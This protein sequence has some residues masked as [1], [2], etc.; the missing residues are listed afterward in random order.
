MLLHLPS[1]LAI[2]CVLTDFENMW[3]SDMEKGGFP[4]SV[5]VV[6]CE[7]VPCLWC[8]NAIGGRSHKAGQ[9][10]RGH[11]VRWPQHPET[12]SPGVKQWCVCYMAL[13]SWKETTRPLKVTMK[14]LPFC[15][16]LFSS[17]HEFWGLQ[18]FCYSA[19]HPLAATL[20]LNPKAKAL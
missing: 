3:A 17:S 16:S 18:C 15:L 11:S 12:N 10:Q 9:G 7:H 5:L 8:G 14:T 6:W 2:L 13:K 19:G 4:L 1:W 20:E